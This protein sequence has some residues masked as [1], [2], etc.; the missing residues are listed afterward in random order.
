MFNIPKTAPQVHVNGRENAAL[1]EVIK[2]TH[3][4]IKKSSF[5]FNYSRDNVRYIRDMCDVL[6][7]S[8]PHFF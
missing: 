4:W 2:T 3:I 5:L 7:T 8:R 6:V 1:R